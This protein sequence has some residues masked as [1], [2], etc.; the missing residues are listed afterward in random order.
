MDEFDWRTGR[1]C[2]HKCFYHLVFSPKYRRKV[3]KENMLERLREVMRET[4]EQ[5]GGALLEFGCESD[6]LH[7]MVV[8]PPSKSVSNF[9]GKL[10]GKSSYVLRSEF[11]EEVKDKLWGDH[12][13]SPSY[14]AVTCGD[15]PLEVVKRYVE[16]QEKPPSEASVKRSISTTGNKNPKRR[17]R[18]TRSY[19]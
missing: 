1:T 8:I 11:W 12:F 7:L 17:G 15:A 10:K 16:N 3:F 14:C 6:H 2:V 5:M 18:L 9:V 19:P 13:W 4:C